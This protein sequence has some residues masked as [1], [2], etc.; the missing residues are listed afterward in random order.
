MLSMHI[1]LMKQY[2]RYPR[3]I[4]NDLYLLMFA[5]ISWLFESIGD[6]TVY[7]PA[8]A[9]SLT[10]FVARVHGDIFATLMM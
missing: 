7:A 9:M 5:R 6:V 1:N 3:K 10:M 2:V 8:V 4:E